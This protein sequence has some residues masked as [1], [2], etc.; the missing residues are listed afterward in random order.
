MWRT[1]I[2]LACS[3]AGALAVALSLLELRA[4][5]PSATGAITGTVR[6]LGKVPPDKDIPVTDGGMIKHNDLVVDPKTKGLRYVV[7]M[8][9]NAPAQP[10]IKQA[11]PVVVDQREWIF[12]PRVVA[13]RHGQAVR[14][15]NS[16]LANHS[17]MSASTV[18]ANQINVIA[19]PG[20]PVEHV[21]EVQKL[22]VQ[23]GCSIHAWMRA[24]VFVIPHPW[25]AV[26]DSQ[27]NFQIADVPPGKYTLW[28]RHPD[29]N[30]QE[31][32]EITVEPG[33][34]V[35]LSIEWKE[36]QAK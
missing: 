25:F 3:S 28:L 29:T 6:F 11:K 24:W 19:A 1:V 36:V 20:Q 22:P 16:D 18:P 27:G 17:V 23:I 10:K 9:E 32:R 21:F 2:V 12:I 5:Q 26:T 13:V 14:F 31:R 35:N 15:E 7:L 8:L 33:K 34:K 30:R 4:V